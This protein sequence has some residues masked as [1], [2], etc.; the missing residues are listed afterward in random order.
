MDVDSGNFNHGGF[1]PL[2]DEEKQKLR[3]TGRCFRCQKKGH[4][5]K[6]CPTRQ[7]RNAEY[8]RPAPTQN[9]HSGITEEPESKKELK[10]V[11]A[12]IKAFLSTEENKQS[13]YD[14]LIELGFV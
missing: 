11:L 9:A 3:N 4:I 1:T 5:S 6:Y 13:F 2:S 10:D 12:D 7:N 8:G 14:G